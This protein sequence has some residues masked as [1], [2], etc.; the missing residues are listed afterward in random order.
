MCSSDLEV[1]AALRL[2]TYQL[3]AGVAPHAAVSETVAVVRPSG[4][5]YVNG[6]LRALGRTGPPFAA[7]DD[8][9]SALSYPDWIIEEFTEAFG[10]DDGRAALEAMNEPPVVTL[11]VNRVRAD[12]AGVLR[13]L[14]VK[15]GRVEGGRLVPDALRV[16]GVGD[17]GA[18]RCVRDGRASP[19]D[20]A[21]QAIVAALDPRPGE[22]VLD[23][24][25]APGGKACAAAERMGDSGMVVAADVH[26]GRLRMVREAAGRLRLAS[27]HA[28]VASG[29]A[30]PF[31]PGLFDRVLLDAP[32]SGL[33]VLRRRPEARWRAQPEQL[34]QLAGLQQRLLAAAATAVRPGGR[35]VYSVCTLSR[36]ETLGVDAWEIGRAHV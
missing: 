15:G 35:L 36:I 4:R 18:L 32:C 26:A 3:L 8:D 16:S 31:A 27:V 12:V 14:E 20:E 9:A 5:K 7:P 2:G 23:V 21:S 28:L 22:R 34:E 11:R 1:R 29:D 30:M 10:A 19:H 25:S 13:E 6:V 24:A 33:G 17:I